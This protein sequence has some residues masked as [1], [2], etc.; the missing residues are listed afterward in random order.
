MRPIVIQ[1]HDHK[2]TIYQLVNK[3]WTSYCI[4]WRQNGERHR[5]TRSSLEDAKQEAERVV[6]DLAIGDGALA[7]LSLKEL[8][9]YQQCERSLN[10]VPLHVAIQAYLRSDAVRQPIKSAPMRVVIHELLAFSKRDN[11]A[12]HT[13]TLRHHLLPLADDTPIDKVTVGELERA[14]QNPEWSKRTRHNHAVSIG[15]LFHFAQRKGY[16]PKGELESDKIERIKLVA[17]TPAIFTPDELCAILNHIPV[18]GIPFVAIG[19]FAGI[20]PQEIQRLTW[21]DIDLPG[22]FIKL[23]S[24]KTKTKRRRVVPLSD[25]LVAWLTEVSG[26]DSNIRP[27]TSV[28]PKRD[29]HKGYTVPAAKT[30]GVRWRQNGLRHSFVSYHLA[31][32]QNAAKTAMISGHTEQQAEE[33]YKEL[34]TQADAQKWF[35]IFPSC[36]EGE[37]TAYYRSE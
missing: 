26:P 34:V 5:R 9:Y 22:K 17:R 24:D 37:I 33:H 6:A 14:I 1:N 28:C 32:E 18:E 12:R 16:L 20:R 10:G 23:T 25:N 29:P 3:D 21:E 31:L 36:I 2:A 4:C 27:D 7:K 15:I 8:Q 19:A 11:S 30:A 13:G 35:S